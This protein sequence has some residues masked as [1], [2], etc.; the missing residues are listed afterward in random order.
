[1]RY[2]SII[3]LFFFTLLSGCKSTQIANKQEKPEDW[4]N[5]AVVPESV[6]IY[7]DTTSI[8]FENGRAYAYE[9][10][11]YTTSESRKLY[12]DKIRDRMD[13]PEKAKKWSDFSY[14]IYER[15]YDCVNQQSR[16]LSVEDFDSTGK[17]ILKTTTAKKNLK[18]VPIAKETI[19]DYTFF[20]VCDYQQ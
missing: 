14:C 2:L 5:V 9:K 11:V 3:I 6:D 10:R 13:K 19:G 8:R 15:E 7:T 4:F 20:F 18:W 16:T 17:S 12:T 1:M